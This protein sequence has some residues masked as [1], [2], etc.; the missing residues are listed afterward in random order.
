V[1]DA[2][3]EVHG[4]MYCRAHATLK[5]VTN[6][7]KPKVDE[8]GVEVP[9]TSNKI[10]LKKKPKF[11]DDFLEKVRSKKIS[12]PN[13]PIK[14][15]SKPG[16]FLNND[17]LDKIKEEDISEKSDNEHS[18]NSN[19]ERTIEGEEVEEIPSDD[20]LPLPSEESEHDED[21]SDDESDEEEEEE[22]PKKIEVKHK[23][24]EFI[25]G[26]LS[27]DSDEDIV[28]EKPP[29]KLSKKELAKQKEIEKRNLRKGK[30][31]SR[32]AMGYLI[33]QGFR[34]GLHMVETQFPDKLKGLGEN[35]EEHKELQDAL[36]DLIK[37]YE[38]II[39]PELVASPEVRILLFTGM[40]M[41][42][43]YRTNIGIKP[44]DDKPIKIDN[45]FK[46]L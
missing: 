35:S 28:K 17:D 8:S 39:D 27:D 22:E 12:P 2:D 18:E 7:P 16:I 34:Y 38:C 44:V 24:R 41:F 45:E 10:L 3:I 14:S 21:E 4:R 26:D 46:D 40:L 25:T 19:A 36:D 37:D 6:P 43:T 29:G 9:N 20:E 31:A 33:H 42:G 15:R 11:K 23:V 32:K 30:E 13:S 5:S 1:K